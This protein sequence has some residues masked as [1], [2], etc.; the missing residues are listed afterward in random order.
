MLKRYPT[1]QL[2]VPGICTGRSTQCHHV[3]DA[4]DDGPDV[5]FLPDGTPQLV[6]VCARCHRYVSARNSAA[7]SGALNGTRAMRE[8][9]RHPGVLP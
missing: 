3:I 2:A 1:C 6:G 8:P 5:E 4:A 7:R 9:E